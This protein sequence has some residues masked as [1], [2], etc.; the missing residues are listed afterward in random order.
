MIPLVFN[1]LSYF[2]IIKACVSRHITVIFA[3]PT[4]LILSPTFTMAEK[5]GARTMDNRL[6]YGLKTNMLYDAALSPNL[7][8]ELKTAPKWSFDFSVSYTP[9]EL[10]DGKK[11]KHLLFQPEAR[12]WLCEA[13]GGHFVAA[14][15]LGGIYNMGQWGHGFKFLNNNLRPLADHRYQGWFA[16]AG[17]AYGY[18]WLLSRHWNIEAEIGFG[19]AYTRYDVYEC[20]GC[21]RKTETDRVHNYVGPTKA[22]LNLVYVF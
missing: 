17:I 9:W 6:E 21:G 2:N 1:V 11:W 10:N 20:K 4:F 22:A 19:W 12:Y 18:S 14:H 15:L 7:A 3:I 8:F 13:T 5:A 16:G